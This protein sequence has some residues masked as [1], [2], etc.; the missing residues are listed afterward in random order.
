MVG[1]GADPYFADPYGYVPPPGEYGILPL[2]PVIIAGGVT[3]AT[4]GAK[5]GVDAKNRHDELRRANPCLIKLDKQIK[6]TIAKMWRTPI[7]TRKRVELEKKA[8]ALKRKRRDMELRGCP[9]KGGKK[10]KSKAQSLPASYA[11]G[12]VAPVA[13]PAPEAG[14][15]GVPTWAWIAGGATLLLAL[16]AFAA[17]RG[18]GG[19]R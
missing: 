2:I 4:T 11:P 18:R 12:A 15:A 10:F 5:I 16:G 19:R 17:G 14:V 3:L 1:Y 7:F 13:P 6:A 8:N 9:Q